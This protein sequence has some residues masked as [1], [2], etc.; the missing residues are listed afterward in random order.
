MQQRLRTKEEV[1][2]PFQSFLQSLKQSFFFIDTK[3]R[4]VDYKIANIPATYNKNKYI[5]TETFVYILII[6]HDILSCVHLPSTEGL[7]LILAYERLLSLS[8]FR[9]TES[10]TCL[11]KCLISE[12]SNNMCGFS[13]RKAYFSQS[14]QSMLTSFAGGY[15][16]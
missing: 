2:F 1:Y 12:G 8:G 10:F 7:K 9:I 14:S 4:S 13:F 15:N 16:G 11:Q 5:F 3:L 6:S